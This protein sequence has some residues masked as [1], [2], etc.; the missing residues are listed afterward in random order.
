MEQQ[1]REQLT[2]DHLYTFGIKCYIF[3][4]KEFL[5]LLINTEQ[6]NHTNSQEYV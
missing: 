3:F 5:F 4:L 6:Y 1:L 2:T